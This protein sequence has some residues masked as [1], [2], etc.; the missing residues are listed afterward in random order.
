VCDAESDQFFKGQP[1]MLYDSL[2]CPK[3]LMRFTA[4]EGAGE[5]C[6]I[7]ALLLF[8]HRVFEWLDATLGVHPDD[9]R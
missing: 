7:G 4:H 5:H 8:N 6:Q 3:T 2:T 1:K 9:A